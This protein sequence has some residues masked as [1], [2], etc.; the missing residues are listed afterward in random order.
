MLTNGCASLEISEKYL[1][2]PLFFDI[3]KPQSHRL[4]YILKWV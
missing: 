3:V 1:S 2:R 4:Q